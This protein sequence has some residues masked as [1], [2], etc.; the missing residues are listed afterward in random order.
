MTIKIAILKT[1]QIKTAFA[2]KTK[3]RIKKY[4]IQKAFYPD[5]LSMRRLFIK[6]FISAEMS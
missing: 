6:A 5:C 3:K 2:Y 4:L 1:L